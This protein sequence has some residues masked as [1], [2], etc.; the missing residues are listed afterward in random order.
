MEDKNNLSITPRF[1]ILSDEMKLS[2]DAYIKKL[3][4]TEKKKCSKH[5][6]IQSPKKSKSKSK[7]QKKE[8]KNKSKI[9]DLNS[10][11]CCEEF[12]KKKFKLGNDFDHDHVENILM[13]LDVALENVELTDKISE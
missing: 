1:G 5:S 9:K 3:V 11:Q 7:S 13:D 8:K 4:K 10:E 6:G 2:E 12:L